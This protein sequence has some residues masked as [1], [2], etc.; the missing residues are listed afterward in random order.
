MRVKEY[1][2]RNGSSPYS[3]WLNG[4]DGSIKYRVQA[5]IMRLKDEGHF[6]HNKHLAEGLYELKFK[7]LGGGIRVYYGLDSD[8]LVILLCGGNKSRQEKDIQQAYKY[9]NDYLCRKEEE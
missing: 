2:K 8:S 5:R 1:L 7:K 4:L 3:Q 6:G 9:W